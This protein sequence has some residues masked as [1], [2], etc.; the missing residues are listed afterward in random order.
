MT[1]IGL[2]KA[3]EILTGQVSTEFIMT[4]AFPKLYLDEPITKG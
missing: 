1:V 4:E 3:V 2:W